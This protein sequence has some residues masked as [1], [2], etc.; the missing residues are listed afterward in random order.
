M[1]QGGQNT[2]REK[3]SKE[4]K[5]WPS[6]PIKN[7]TDHLTL[8]EVPTHQIYVQRR[9][10]SHLPSSLSP[11]RD[12]F[13]YLEDQGG[14]QCCGLVVACNS[15]L[16]RGFCCWYCCFCSFS[17]PGTGFTSCRAAL[18]L[19]VQRL[20]QPHYNIS[21][22]HYPL[23]CL[24]VMPA[25][26]VGIAVTSCQCFHSISALGVVP[27]VASTFTNKVNI[28]PSLDPAEQNRRQLRLQCL[29]FSIC[30]CL[31]RTFLFQLLWK[32]PSCSILFI[33]Q[34]VVHLH[35]KP[36]F[37]PCLCKEIGGTKENSFDA[38]GIKVNHNPHC[39]FALAAKND[40]RI[41]LKVTYSLD[42]M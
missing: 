29:L 11:R 19:F 1:N 33:G 21:L 22:E 13:S 10:A 36:C 18:N 40:R 7:Q 25:G 3:F 26:A 39:S 20:P 27:A 41:R 32:T 34:W 31:S 42:Q 16:T 30:L 14:L 8:K 38:A 9:L 2:E 15:L 35:S 5:T 6:I 23:Q 24:E 37:L 17:I 4:N 28:V 12:S